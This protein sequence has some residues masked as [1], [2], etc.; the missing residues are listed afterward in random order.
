MSDGWISGSFS[1]SVDM[2][3]NDAAGIPIVSSAFSD[4]M[5]VVKGG[6]NNCLTKDGQNSPTANLPMGGQRHTGVGKPA[7]FDDYDRVN[8]RLHNWNVYALDTNSAGTSITISCSVAFTVTGSAGHS[9][10]IIAGQDKPN[11]AYQDGIL[12]LNSIT[13]SVVAGGNKS[14]WPGAIN[15]NVPHRLTWNERI[16]KYVIENPLYRWRKVSNVYGGRKAGGAKVTL[17]AGA[18]ATGTISCD[19]FRWHDEAHCHMTNSSRVVFFSAGTSADQVILLTAPDDM[20][21]T[22]TRYAPLRAVG[23]AGADLIYGFIKISTDGK[24]IA[25]GGKDAGGTQI[26]FGG[27]GII[28]N[29]AISWKI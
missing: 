22:G 14:L 1:I 21:P 26:G 6:I 24:I 15:T 18:T 3:V 20:V 4:Q 28:P 16:N 9:I 27:S 8:E 13:A 23:S 19:V 2:S 29:F 12:M 5:S 25:D 10:I 7:A 17:P 11:G